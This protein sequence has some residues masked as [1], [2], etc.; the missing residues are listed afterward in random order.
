MGE[1][2]RDGTTG[3]APRSRGR[4]ASPGK[5]AATRRSVVAA[6]SEVFLER[7]FAAARMIDVANRAGVAKGTLYLYF[8]D[9]EA[10][11]EGVL[12]E[13]VAEPIAGLN[14]AA[15]GPE[16]SVRS[17]LARAVPPIL[18]DLEGSRRAAVAR[19]V[20]A[21]GGRFPAL[22][23]M[24]RRLVIEPGT[25]AVRR[26]AERA[27]ARGELASDALARY[28]QLLAAPGVMATVWNGLYGADRPLDTAAVFEA[29]LDLVF[30]PRAA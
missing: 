25:E 3:A 11:F 20:I 5:T 12:Q 7:G 6:A 17:Y 23:E 9:K 19:L 26:L 15:P 27:V 28:P 14:A 1:T 16:E 22:A 4:G 10:L 24:Y 18:R 21:E 2:G 29:Y 8:A 30:P 13:A